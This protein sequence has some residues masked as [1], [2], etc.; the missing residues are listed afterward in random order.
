MSHSHPLSN[1]FTIIRNA[2][3]AKH[4]SVSVPFSN[5]K[6]AICKILKDEGFIKYYEIESEKLQKKYIKIGLK[7]NDD[8]TSMI[9]EIRSVSLPGKRKYVQKSEIT[10]VLNGFGV[11]FYSTSKGVLSGRAARLANVGG[12]Y[13]GYVY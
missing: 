8:G 11:S 2:I 13:L 9:S 4:S 10:K 1:M 5:L 3:K 7:F 12:E 6:L